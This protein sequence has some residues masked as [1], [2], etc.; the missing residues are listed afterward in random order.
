MRCPARCET[1]RNRSLPV[2]AADH[3][4]PTT[5]STTATVKKSGC[6][7]HRRSPASSITRASYSLSKQ[8]I[9]RGVRLISP[10]RRLSGLMMSIFGRSSLGKLKR[11]RTSDSASSIRMPRFSTLCRSRSM[12]WRPIAL[13]DSFSILL[14]E[15]GADERRHHGGP[16]CRR[17]PTHCA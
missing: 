2:A 11:A 16:A 12:T 8:P 5:P 3:R 7:R 6:P 15:G 13:A 14:G 10:L 4:P 17:A 1:R 9:F